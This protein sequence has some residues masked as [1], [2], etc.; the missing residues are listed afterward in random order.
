M[1]WP[2]PPEWRSGDIARPPGLDGCVVAVDDHLL[3]LNK[4]CGLLAVPGRGPENADCLS[5]RVQAQWPDARVVHRLDMATSG[6][7]VMA[8]GPDA[9]R[10]LSEAFA[11]RLTHKRYEAVV[12]GHVD[13]TAHPRNADG[14]HT[15]DLPLVVDWP[16]RPRSIVCHTLGKPSLTRWRVIEHGVQGQHSGGHTRLALEPVTGR[17]HQ[18]RVHLLALGHPILGDMLYA[19]AAAQAQALRLLLHATRLCLPHPVTGQTVEWHSPAPF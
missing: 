19:P 13:D 4:P 10:T 15:T 3:V 8:R 5:A 6:L 2:H 1:N 17:S 12:A 14:W 7:M 11:K 18:L 9:Q 16:N